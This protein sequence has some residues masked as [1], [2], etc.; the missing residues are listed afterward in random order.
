MKRTPNQISTKDSSTKEPPTGHLTRSRTSLLKNPSLDKN[1]IAAEEMIQDDVIVENP[2]GSSEFFLKGFVY[3]EN[4]N[5][6]NNKKNDY[7][8]ASRRI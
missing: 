6:E 8:Y 4:L 3:T 7:R 1:A 2:P 5:Y